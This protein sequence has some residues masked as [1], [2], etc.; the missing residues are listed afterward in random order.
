MMTTYFTREHEWIKVDGD[1]ATVGI[2][3]HAQ[4]A[5]G[6]IVFTEV[7]DAGKQLSKGQEAAVVESV[8]AASDVYSPVSGEVTEGNQAVVDDPSLVNSD[9]EGA[10]WFFKLKLSNS[11]ELDGLMNEADY[12]DWVET[13]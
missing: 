10:G 12:R 1:T 9:P 2:T 6:D 11:G 8:K 13:L 3:D 4:E 7:P 5:L